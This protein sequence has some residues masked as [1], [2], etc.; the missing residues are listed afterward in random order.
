MYP[1]LPSGTV[2]GRYR[3][4]EEVGRGGMGVVYRAR[5]TRLERPVAL[6][7]LSPFLCEDRRMLARFQ[8]EAVTIAGLKHPHIAGVYEFGEQAGLPYIAFEWMEGISLK[9][10][11]AKEG[12]LAPER[13]ARIVAQVSSALAYIH[14][15]GIIHRD[16]KPANINIGP[17]DQVTLLDFGMAF[18]PA[19]AGLTTTNAIVGTPRYMSPEQ[20]EGRPLDGCSDQYSLAIVAYELL[21]GCPP[22]TND[23]TPA[24]LHAHVYAPP[25]PVTEHNPTLP[26]QVEAVLGRA[27]AKQPADRYPSVAEFSAALRV[28]VI[29][30]PLRTRD[31]LLQAVLKPLRRAAGARAAKRK[32]RPPRSSTRPD[33]QARRKERQPGQ[34]RGFRPLA[35]L[36]SRVAKMSKW[37][38]A[39]LLLVGIPT[40]C[41]ALFAVI[42]LLMDG[43]P[44]NEP[45]NL[46][47]NLPEPNLE[48]LLTRFAQPDWRREPGSN[49]V[50]GLASAGGKVIAGLKNGAVLALDRHT[51]ATAWETPPSISV[52]TGVFALGTPGGE[53]GFDAVQGA[54]EGFRQAQPAEEGAGQVFISTAN[55]GLHALDLTSGE[56][57]WSKTIADLHG[58]LHSPVTAGPDGLIYTATDQGWVH[59]IQPGDGSLVW[60]HDLSRAGPF[61]QPPAINGDTLFLIS[62]GQILTAF[63]PTTQEEVWTADVL[64]QPTT[65]PAYAQDLN[66]L[67]LGTDKGVYAFWADRGVLA[68]RGPVN[69]PI[70]G[71]MQ[72]EGRVYATCKD[73]SVHVWLAQQGEKEWGLGLTN[74]LTTAPILLP[75]AV[76][77]AGDGG[78]F[79]A[80]Q[81]SGPPVGALRW[82]IDFPVAFTPTLGEDGLYLY[83]GVE[84]LGFH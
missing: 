74:Q 32:E 67:F 13:T 26:V 75:E 12:P 57:L 46:P 81:H 66:L 3:I 49:V 22:F 10:L 68:W 17:G 48:L 59:A 70:S 1:S 44:N 2:I 45:Y 9:A 79:L 41:C 56:H 50:T 19:A 51:G 76:L 47:V 43:Q 14:Q 52:I 31:R 30:P 69:S 60:S 54:E 29:P 53:D 62:E 7:L 58:N 84:I 73:G 35:A 34:R 39:G 65:P 38:L 25:P 78:E 15:H 8:R 21:C 4:E 36:G 83:N 71:L 16:V 64:G 33:R 55:N 63:N 72:D 11:L 20:V 37:K 5:E 61:F 6:K 27:L 40:L 18:L 28:A 24:L 23:S 80:F 82:T 77:V 42:A